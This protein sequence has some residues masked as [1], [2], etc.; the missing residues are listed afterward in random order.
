MACAATTSCGAGSS[1]LYTFPFGFH[2]QP[3]GPFLACVLL[4]P[5]DQNIATIV[6]IGPSGRKTLSPSYSLSFAL[7]VATVA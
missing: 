5:N 2:L 4:G 6:A 1:L 7:H 3:S